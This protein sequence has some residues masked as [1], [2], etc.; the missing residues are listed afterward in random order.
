MATDI[1]PAMDQG[2]GARTQLRPAFSAADGGRIVGY[3]PAGVLVWGGLGKL[4]DHLTG[5]SYFT[6]I[7]LA[8]GLVLATYLVIHYSM[9]W[10]PD[11]SATKPKAVS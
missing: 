11:E 7:G 8:L 6:P 5:A 10:S 9:R 4:V 1:V 2:S 3:L